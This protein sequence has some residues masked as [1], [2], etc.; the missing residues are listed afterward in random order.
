MKKFILFAFT[1][2]CVG[3]LTAPSAPAQAFPG[4]MCFN[5][6]G[7]GH[8]EVCVKSDQFEPTGTCMKIAGCY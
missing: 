2:F 1:G 7:C 5:S 3:Y 6:G 8:C 4:A